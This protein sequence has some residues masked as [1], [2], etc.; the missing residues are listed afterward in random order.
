MHGR[1]EQQLKPGHQ[2]ESYSSESGDKEILKDI[3][4]EVHTGDFYYLVGRVGSGKSTLLKAI[5]GDI[6]PSA[7]EAM[8]AG[9][10]LMHLKP[11]TFQ[12]SEE[13]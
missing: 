7:G 4:L 9:Y 11:S 2:N 1:K 13:N 10:D 8:V 5:Y 12:N 6:K 3:N